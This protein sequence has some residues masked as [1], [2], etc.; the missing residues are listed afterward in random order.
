[1]TPRCVH[2]VA[3]MEP[4]ALRCLMELASSGIAPPPPP[5]YYRNAARGAAPKTIEQELRADV[6]RMLKPKSALAGS[7]VRGAGQSNRGAVMEWCDA[8]KEFEVIDDA[9]PPA[10]PKREAPAQVLQS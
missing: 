3:Q 7:G 1:M 8:W 5:D 4:L 6:A 9:A 2:G 10:V